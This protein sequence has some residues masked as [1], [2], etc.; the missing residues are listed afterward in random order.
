MRTVSLLASLCIVLMA[1]GDNRKD[2]VEKDGTLDSTISPSEISTDKAVAHST[3]HTNEDELLV[4]VWQDSP[5]MTSGWSTT[6]QFFSDGN[7]ILNESQMD[8]AKRLVWSKGR[9]TRASKEELEL[10]ITE[11]LRLEGG[12]MMASDGSC[13]SDSMLIGASEKSKTFDEPKS[14]TMSIGSF[15]EGDQPERATI[16]INGTTYYRFSND[17]SA[18]P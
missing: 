16:E 15:T 5:T 8:C 11:W 2:R 13:G 12:R 3:S 9:W 6:Y 14:I 7:F 17:P 4:G 10:A 1:C 18:Y